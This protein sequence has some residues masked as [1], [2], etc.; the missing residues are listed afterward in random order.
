MIE[1][2]V[3]YRQESLVFKIYRYKLALIVGSLLP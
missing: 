2:I 1:N 3:S